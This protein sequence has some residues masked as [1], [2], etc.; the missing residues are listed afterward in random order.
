MHLHMV[1]FKNS[2]FALH[3]ATY[4]KVY[5]LTAN[6]KNVQLLKCKEIPDAFVGSLRKRANAG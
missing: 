1:F 3:S 5:N 4:F 6:A 2:I